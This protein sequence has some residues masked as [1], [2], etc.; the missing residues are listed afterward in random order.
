MSRS[1]TARTHM[2][3]SLIYCLSIIP[4]PAIAQSKQPKVNQLPPACA[5]LEVPNKFDPYSKVYSTSFPFTEQLVNQYIQRGDYTQALK[6]AQTSSVEENIAFKNNLIPG[7]LFQFFKFGNPNDSSAMIDSLIQYA[8]EIRPSSPLGE[9]VTLNTIAEIYLKNNRVP[10]AL[11][12]SRQAVVALKMKD[13]EAGFRPDKLEESFWIYLEQKQYEGAIKVAEFTQDPVY[14]VKMRIHAAAFSTDNPKTAETLISETI[15]LIQKLDNQRDKASFLLNIANI[16]LEIQQPKKAEKF[17]K[18]AGEMIK[19]FEPSPNRELMLIDMAQG[20]EKLQQLELANRLYEEAAENTQ[21]YRHL[22]SF[23]DFYVQ[24]IAGY[25]FD[26]KKPELAKKLLEDLIQ[27][28]ADSSYRQMEILKIY[29][30]ARE[31][32]A[33]IKLA[34]SFSREFDRG[35]AKK[36]IAI[37]YAKNGDFPKAV[38]LMQSISESSQKSFAWVDLA[39][40]AIE[41]KEVG[42]LKDLISK[43]DDD[44][45]RV[46]MIES[47]IFRSRYTQESDLLKEIVDFPSLVSNPEQRERLTYFLAKAYADLGE[48]NLALQL[49]AQPAR[50]QSTMERDRRDAW[51]RLTQK[52]LENGNQEALQQIID[53]ANPTEKPEILATMSQVYVQTRQRDNALASL[54]QLMPLIA[55]NPAKLRLA[56]NLYQALGEYGKALEIAQGLD[57]TQ[58]EDF[59]T[60][61]QVADL[62]VATGKVEQAKNYLNTIQ[63]QLRQKNNPENLALQLIPLAVSYAQAGDR[64]QAEKLLTEASGLIKGLKV[65]DKSLLQWKL[66][67]GYARVAGFYGEMGNK[68]KAQ[69]LFSVAQTLSQSLPGMTEFVRCV[70]SQI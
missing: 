67:G 14:Q 37:S 19:Q 20:Y 5:S 7:I 9:G 43:T 55:Q 27:D 11:Q 60:S 65:Q 24:M 62:Y 63:T 61:F 33:A 59:E 10:E 54:S 50:P 44:R 17:L 42:I 1:F 53:R 39:R 23:G 2:T 41:K 18:N 66:M 45:A 29:T 32:E 35:Q 4:L 68:T 15:P 8:K 12:L 49:M 69:E 21:K 28:S 31:Y 13:P 22:E 58:T 6:F 51:Q 64:L 40:V 46:E 48:F 30:N 16:Y 57:L 47:S 3:L 38:S 56:A 70:Q 52:A 26:Y 25:Y 36:E 34:N